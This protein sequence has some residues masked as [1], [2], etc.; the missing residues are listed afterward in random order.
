MPVFFIVFRLALGIVLR[1][2]F[3]TNTFPL[4]YNR[5]KILLSQIDLKLSTENTDTF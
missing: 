4:L 2:I 3:P 5:R 1:R